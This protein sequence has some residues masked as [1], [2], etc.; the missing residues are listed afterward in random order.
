VGPIVGLDAGTKRKILCP[1]RGSNPDRPAPDT[2]LTELPR[3]LPNNVFRE[4][5][6]TK[7]YFEYKNETILCIIYGYV[8]RIADN[9]QSKQVLERIPQGKRKTGRPRVRWRESLV[10]C[11]RVLE[12]QQMIREER[13][14][15]I[16]SVNDVNRSTH[17]CTYLKT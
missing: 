15:G 6:I 11:Q 12:G 7:L 2:T 10:Q 8:H 14:L 4:N 5:R 9:R 3:L 17:P 13:R 16:R 1:C